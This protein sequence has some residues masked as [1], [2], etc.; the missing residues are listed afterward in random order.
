MIKKGQTLVILLIFMA[1]AI[2]ITSAAVVVIIVNSKMGSRWEMGETALAVAESGAENAMLRL[3]RDPTYAGETL[4]V[5]PGSATIEVT[6]TDP[7]ITVSGTVGDFTRKVRVTTGY[8]GSGALTVNT[9]TED[10]P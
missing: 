9:W 6:G 3:L 7:I 10:W 5:G 2:T 1:M 8:S 4:T